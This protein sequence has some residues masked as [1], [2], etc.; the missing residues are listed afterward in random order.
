VTTIYEYVGGEPTFLALAAA[1][2]ERCVADPQLNHAFGRGNLRPDHTDRLGRYLAEVFGGPANYT[3]RYHEG[4][5]SFVLDIHAGK[6]MNA[7][8]GA[9]FVNCFVAAFDDV[10]L[11]EDERLR[12]AMRAYMEWAMADVLTYTPPGS[13]VPSDLSMPQWSWEPSTRP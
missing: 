11:P 10:G 6:D 4:G 9:R 7:A 1:T 13:T 3:G 5:H 12:S 8:F 2:H